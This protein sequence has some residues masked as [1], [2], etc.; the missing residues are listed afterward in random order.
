MKKTFL[1]AAVAAVTVVGSSADAAERPSFE[2]MGFTITPH[3]VSVVGA[4]KVQEQSSTATLTLGGMPA[5]PHQVAVLTRPKTTAGIAAK[6][7]AAG[8]PSQ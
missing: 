8:V 4:P 3:Q 5:S 6:R 2:L 1:V 7:I